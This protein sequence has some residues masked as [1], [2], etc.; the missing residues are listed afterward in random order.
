LLL[1]CESFFP[2]KLLIFK[3]Y[4]PIL[5]QNPITKD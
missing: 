5:I 2:P 4:L 1:L 3:L